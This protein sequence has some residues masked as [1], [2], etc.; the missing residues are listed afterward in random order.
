MSSQTTVLTDIFT[1]D[2]SNMIFAVPQ[3]STVN[4]V[5][6]KRIPISTRN[7]DGTIGD[8]IIRTCEVFS[9][10]VQETKSLETEK[11][12]GYS[13][14]LCLWNRNGPTDEEIE[15]IRCFELVVE[16]CKEHL[17]SNGKAIGRRDLEMRD[18]RTFSPIYRKRNDEGEIIETRGPLLY[19]KVILSRKNNKEN[20]LTIFYDSNSNA[21]LN[22]LDIINKACTT[23]AAIKIESIF[24]G[25]GAKTLSLQIK[26]WE[27]DCKIQQSG[28]KRLLGASSF[29]SS[30][31]V[32]KP[33]SPL[34]REEKESG[35]IANS[36]EDEEDKFIPQLPPKL[37][38]TTR[39]IAQRKTK[40]DRPSNATVATFQ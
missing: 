23:I 32:E 1:Y 15:W 40:P 28:V 4:A 30:Q 14:P 24:I 12:T 19:P 35:S 2:P 39:K 25:N 17:V 36:D 18:L 6:Y 38:S 26:I 20:I 29:S 7:P 8:L 11:V 37:E 33:T 5:K 13:M 10:G 22:L 34:L 3:E 9:F 21:D 27:A 16:K 31:S